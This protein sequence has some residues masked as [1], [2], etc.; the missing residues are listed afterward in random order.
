MEA[1]PGL[2]FEMFL[3]ATLGM[4]VGRMRREMASDEYARW[5]VYFARKAQRDELARL[6]QKG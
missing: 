4:T 6:Q 1:D 2:E 3:A 5:G